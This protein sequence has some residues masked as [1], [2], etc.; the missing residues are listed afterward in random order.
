MATLTLN[1]LGDFSAERDGQ[2]LRF[3]YDKMRA[4]LAYLAVEHERPHRRQSLATLL[5]P[6]HDKRGALGNLSQA[7]YKLRTTMGEGA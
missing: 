2:P 5:W 3:G 6:E 1:L 4:L 7:L